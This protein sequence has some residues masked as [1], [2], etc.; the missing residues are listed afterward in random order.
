MHTDVHIPFRP[1][2]SCFSTWVS[3][4]CARSGSEEAQPISVGE[5]GDYKHRVEFAYTS[6]RTKYQFVIAVVY[7]SSTGLNERGYQRH[8]GTQQSNKN[9]HSFM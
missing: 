4:G 5:V 3:S 6:G 9:F 2:S 8:L 7:W 1:G